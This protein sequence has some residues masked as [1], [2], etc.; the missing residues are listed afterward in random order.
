[1]I[2][3]VMYRTNPLRKKISVTNTECPEI[4]MMYSSLS[5]LSHRVSKQGNQLQ[6]LLRCSLFV[7]GCKFCI[8]EFKLYLQDSIE[9]IEDFGKV[10]F[11]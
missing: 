10:R 6:C 4:P 11:V 9:T 8:S 7:Y 5:V 1:M 3:F 2:L